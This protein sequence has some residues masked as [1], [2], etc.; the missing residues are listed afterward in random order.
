MFGQSE[1]NV[2][3][4]GHR[5]YKALYPENTMIS[6]KK[7]IEIG[8]DMI[9]M[10]LNVTADRQLV[11]IHD[12]TLDRTT[13]GN[14]KVRDFTLK[15]IKS[16]DAGIFKGEEFA[17]ERV[18]EFSEFLDLVSKEENLYL[19]VEIKDRTFEAVDL[20]I[21]ALDEYNMLDKI[22]ITCFDASIVRYANEKYGVKTQG[23]PSWYVSNFDE[24]TYRHV[25]AVGIHMKDLSRALCID[26]RSRGIDP[27]GYCPDTDEMVYKA[28]ESK[29]SLVTCNNPEP[30]LRIL[31][32]KG[33][34]K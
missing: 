17:G 5:G 20:T 31:R 10:D 15:E 3:V 21:K 28:I 7:A 27:W 16:L 34:H 23:F 13:N 19:N 24:H 18:P 12:T 9:E 8:V 26:F 32:E 22:V 4:A 30:A 14:G 6:F 29:C 11:I 2:L 25:Y 33:L 1:T